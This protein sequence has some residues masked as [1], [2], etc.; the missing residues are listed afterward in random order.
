MIN[1]GDRLVKVVISTGIDRR[2]SED[3]KSTIT[4]HKCEATKAGPRSF[5]A[6][7]ARIQQGSISNVLD[8]NIMRSM[9]MIVVP[10]CHELGAVQLAE[11]YIIE[12]IK[13]HEKA[14]AAAYARAKRAVTAG[15][16]IIHK[17]GKPNDF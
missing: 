3:I 12:A 13:K 2:E 6:A 7:G 16:P 5:V 8:H 14:T 1:N 15:F 11:E 4:V 9:K 17:E 10:A